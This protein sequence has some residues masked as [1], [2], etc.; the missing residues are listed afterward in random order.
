MIRLNCTILT[1][2]WFTEMYNAQPFIL[3]TGRIKVAHFRHIM[4]FWGI[5]QQFV[6]H[7][8]S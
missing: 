5:F 4:L 3:P 6:N 2:L 8:R 7:D 1:Y